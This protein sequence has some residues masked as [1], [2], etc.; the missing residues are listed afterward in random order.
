MVEA[1]NS[2]INY[3]DLDKLFQ[4]SVERN[5]KGDGNT[6]GSVISG[7]TYSLVW[8]AFSKWCSQ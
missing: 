3:Y 4:E 7:A 2:G 8:S 5:F 6:V 1:S